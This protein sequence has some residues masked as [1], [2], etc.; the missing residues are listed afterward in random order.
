MAIPVKV[1]NRRPDKVWIDW[2][3]ANSSPQAQV[4]QA[5]DLSG[6]LA[7][8]L[9]GVKLPQPRGDAKARLTKLEETYQA[10]LITADEYQ[11]KRAE[12]LKDL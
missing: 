6:P 11:A 1:H 4:V 10:G 12:I 7:D 3:R 5:S 2:E 8:A 9:K